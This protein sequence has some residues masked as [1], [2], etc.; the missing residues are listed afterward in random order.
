MVPDIIVI[1]KGLS[2]G[3][4]PMSATCYRRELEG[5]FHKNPFIHIS[6]FGGAEVGCLVAM[7]VL[8]ESS[9]PEFLENV[10]ELVILF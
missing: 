6:T 10:N 1:G 8:E 7:A 9:K 5:F 3:I 4:Y 2:G